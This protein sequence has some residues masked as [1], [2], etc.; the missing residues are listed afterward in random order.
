MDE[1]GD[2][3]IDIGMDKLRSRFGF[4]IVVHPHDP[5]TIYV[6]LEESDQ[7][8]MSVDGQVAV[9][10]SRDG[11]ESWQRITAGLPQEAHVVGPRPATRARPPGPAGLSAGPDTGHSV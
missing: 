10:R 8:R 3:W 4:P 7:F 6:M 11:G 9:W 2:D 1:W 5:K